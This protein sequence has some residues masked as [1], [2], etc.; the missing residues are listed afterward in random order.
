VDVARD[1]DKLE[2]KCRRQNTQ[3]SWVR[4]A[5]EDMDMVLDDNDDD[6]NESSTESEEAAALR[7]QLKVKKN[8]LRSLLSKPVFPR[9]FSGKY[10]D[11]NLNI[12]P[13]Q[14]TEKAIEVMKKVIENN[15]GKKKENNTVPRKR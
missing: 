7:R 4:K 2:L 12:D 14:D 1:I 3:K 8:Q 6:G 5:M 15:P 11:D 9:G 10:L 13:A